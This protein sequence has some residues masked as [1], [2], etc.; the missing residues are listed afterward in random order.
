MTDFFK[1]INLGTVVFNIGI[2]ALIFLLVWRVVNRGDV[3]SIPTENVE[4]THIS[5]VCIQGDW[6]ECWD[7]PGGKLVKIYMVKPD[8]DGENKIL[9]IKPTR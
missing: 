7:F 4:T 9:F 2:V 6:D 3:E 5:K 8:P 1:N